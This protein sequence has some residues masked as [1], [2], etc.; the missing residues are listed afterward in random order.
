MTLREKLQKQLEEDY[1]K[2]PRK[3]FNNN[4]LEMIWNENQHLYIGIDSNGEEWIEAIQNT[5]VPIFSVKCTNKIL[6]NEILVDC[7]AI[8]FT[9]IFN[10]SELKCRKCNKTFTTQLE[11][12][13][14]SQAYKI[15]ENLDK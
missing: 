4:H 11:V 8:N 14:S 12:P 9:S 5:R 1:R 3:I 15:L 10:L 13:K 6:K 7:G 2:A